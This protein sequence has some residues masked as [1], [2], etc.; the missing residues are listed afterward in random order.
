M[1]FF[2]RSFKT[3]PHLGAICI[4]LTLYCVGMAAAQT[5]PAGFLA[6]QYING[7]YIPAGL[8]VVGTAIMK[9]IGCLMLLLSRSF[10][11]PGKSTTTVSLLVSQQKSR[12]GRV[13]SSNGE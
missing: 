10:W 12:R 4:V 2:S 1:G 3:V 5:K 9:R 6:P 13:P 11:V 7:V 8:L